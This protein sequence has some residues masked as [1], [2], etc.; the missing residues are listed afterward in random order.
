M[1][2]STEIN[3]QNLM[4]EASKG[5]SNGL[6]KTNASVENNDLSS[7][8]ILAHTCLRQAKSISSNKIPP[9]VPPKPVALSLPPPLPTRPLK[10]FLDPPSMIRTRSD[11]VKQCNIDYSSDEEEY[12]VKKNVNNKKVPQGSLRIITKRNKL[13]RRSSTSNISCSAPSSPSVSNPLNAVKSFLSLP[14]SMAAQAAPDADDIFLLTNGTIDPHILVPAQTSNS[15]NSLQ[16]VTANSSYLP[17][18]PQAPLVTIYQS[19]QKKLDDLKK[20]DEEYNSI[21]STLNRVRNIHMSATTVPTILQFQPVLIAYQLTLIDSIIFRNI[22]MDAIL[23]HSPKT[24][25]PSIVAS[26][27]FFNY[28]TRLIEHAILLQ[29]DASGRAQH[30]NHWIKVAGKCHE[31]KNYQTLKAV[32]SALGTPPIQRL[33]KSWSFIPKK[34]MNLLEDLSELM[35]EASNYGKYRTRLGLSQDEEEEV[36]TQSIP[37]T[38]T[39]TTTNNNNNNSNTTSASANN[40]RKS[41]T[42]KNSFSEPTVPFLGIFIHDMTYLV[43]A[44]SKKQNNN[45]HNSQWTTTASSKVASTDIHEMQQDVRV[46]ELLKLFK[47]LQRSPPYSPHLTAVCIK[48]LNKNR[49]RKLSHAL[50]RSSAIKKT[51]AYFANQHDD[52]TG[53]ELSIE[54]QQCLVTQYL[55][56]RSWVSEKTVDELSLVREPTK[57]ARSYSVTESLANGPTSA[58]PP[59]TSSVSL[60]TTTRS[61]SGSL[62]SSS[63]NS[64]PISL[65]DELEQ[66]EMERKSSTS[67]GFWLFNRKSTDAGYLKSNDS[68][69]TMQ[70]SPRHFSFEELNNAAMIKSQSLKPYNDST[71]RMQREGSQS[72]LSTIFRKDFWKGSG[73]GTVTNRNPLLNFNSD[74]SLLTSAAIQ[75]K[76]SSASLVQPSPSSSTDTH[77]PFP[78]R[79]LMTTHPLDDSSTP[80]SE[81]SSFNWDQ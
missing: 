29:Q 42:R 57:T 24:P 44:L 34:S 21:Q 9:T 61:S 12:V 43:A 5:Y 75:R 25:H 14:G 81:I 33:K 73:G 62:T 77:H 64:R 76:G 49:K 31:L 32:I 50:T 18:I 53:G 47:N 11:F 68:F 60:T 26:T 56:T 38:A 8:F 7:V 1:V 35:S 48:D 72:S 13:P 27:D 66:D 45:R 22:P 16:S 6:F 23:S 70:R 67:T 71:H 51:P 78:I 15:D 79:K 19:L 39:T 20:T 37:T 58:T 80:L 63:S 4:H 10:T 3:M 41:S 28:L 55:L 17:F 46:S 2:S 52:E 74:P 40:T 69:G 36:S 54:M 30:I 59:I 65:E